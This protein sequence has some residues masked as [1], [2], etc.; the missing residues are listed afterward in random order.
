MI[1]RILSSKA[2]QA[3]REE[4]TAMTR[5]KLLRRMELGASRGRPDLINGLL[6]KQDGLVSDS[7]MP[8]NND[9]RL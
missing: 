8:K 1:L 6:Q 3:R 2:L 9:S 7:L 4:H 5:D